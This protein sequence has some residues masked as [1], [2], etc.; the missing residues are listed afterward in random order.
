MTR[1]EAERVAAR[2]VT[3]R[4]SLTDIGLDIVVCGH[5]VRRERSRHRAEEVAAAERDAI[6]RA[7]VEE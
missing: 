2:L 6:V 5:G 4:P 7:L 3:V 1:A